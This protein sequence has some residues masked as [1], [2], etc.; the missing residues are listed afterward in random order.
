MRH[1]TLLILLLSVAVS[2]T[3]QTTFNAVFHC[4]NFVSLPSMI[5]RVQLTPLAPFADF[6]NVILDDSPIVGQTDTNG[7]VTFSNLFSGYSYI[8]ELDTSYKTILRTNGFPSGLTGIISAEAYIGIWLPG[9]TIFAYTTT[10]QFQ[11]HSTNLDGWSSLSTNAVA[12][13]SQLSAQSNF[14]ATNVVYSTGLTA[15]TNSGVV[16]VTTNGAVS[17]AG[18]VTANTPNQNIFQNP[19][20]LGGLTTSN[21]AIFQQVSP[22]AGFNMYWNPGHSIEAEEQMAATG[23]LSF[24]LGT[25]QTKLSVLQ[26]TGSGAYDTPILAQYDT[27]TNLMGWGTPIIFGYKS[28]PTTN[29]LTNHYW[30]I[31]P[32]ATDTNGGSV[33][34]IYSAWSGGDTKFIGAQTDSLPQN[35]VALLSKTN[36][37]YN[38]NVVGTNGGIFGASNLLAGDFTTATFVIADPLDTN[39]TS[40]PFQF[41]PGAISDTI[42]IGKQAVSGTRQTVMQWRNNSGGIM[43]SVDPINS[44]VYIT[45]GYQLAVGKTTPSNTVDVAGG[46]ST[47]SIVITNSFTVQHTNTAP[48]NATTPALWIDVTNG[49]SVFRMPL[50][51]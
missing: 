21:S 14:F 12:Y 7:V 35:V 11:P 17:L 49:G 23:A 26:L 39:A 50:Y 22:G 19:N 27:T 18:L 3:A 20:F 42:Y 31:S 8:F 45:S 24:T 28:G 47:G 46:I 4:T 25:D 6:T 43:T 40:S 38:G 48:G 5:N 36:F 16:T 37:I 32:I 10:N 34:K 33:L 29:S 13:L 41:V 15:T 1:I 51:Q 2:S 30:G 44:R 9:Q